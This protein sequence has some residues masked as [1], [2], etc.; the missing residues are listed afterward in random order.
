MVMMTTRLR[1]KETMWHIWFFVGNFMFGCFSLYPLY[2]QGG[3]RT[4]YRYTWEY[5]TRSSICSFKLLYPCCKCMN[6]V[7]AL[8]IL[9]CQCCNV[10]DIGGEMKDE[11]VVL[12]RGI[13]I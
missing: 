2:T 7:N 11:G 9:M 8:C 5:E 13:I 3:A 10:K 6:I 1:T 4:L 12:S